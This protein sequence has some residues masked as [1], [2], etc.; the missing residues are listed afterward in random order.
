MNRV[1]ACW[2]KNNRPSVIEFTCLELPVRYEER[3]RPYWPRSTHAMEDAMSRPN[4]WSKSVPRVELDHRA[5]DARVRLVWVERLLV[6]RAPV[7]SFWLSPFVR[8]LGSR[9]GGNRRNGG[10]GGGSQGNP[11]LGCMPEIKT[12]SSASNE[13]S[14]PI[15]HDPV[16]QPA[17]GAVAMDN[18]T[19]PS[20][21]LV[22]LSGGHVSCWKNDIGA[23]T[24]AADRENDG[25][26][27]WIT[28][29]IE[30]TAFLRPAPRGAKMV[31]G[32]RSPPACRSR[33]PAPLAIGSNRSSVR[34]CAA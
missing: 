11:R 19:K 22:P 14:G 30:R 34:R 15:S 18:S 4:L 25:Q 10:R 27:R 9:T 2:W 26:V 13:A 28:Y 8:L 17:A 29:D 3:P 33:R 20:T 32:V 7:A 6:P 12:V 1:A 24:L 5:R 31:E 16:N 23:I 21:S